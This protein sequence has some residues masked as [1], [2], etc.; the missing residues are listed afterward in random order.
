MTSN[1]GKGPAN[2]VPQSSRS[3]YSMRP[4]TRE[5]ITL[6]DPSEP[7]SSPEGRRQGDQSKSTSLESSPNHDADLAAEERKIEEIQE[8]IQRRKQALKEKVARSRTE[9]L[10]EAV[11]ARQDFERELEDLI[12]IQTEE[13]A[14]DP[15]PGLKRRRANTQGDRHTEPQLND[16]QRETPRE[17][18]DSIPSSRRRAPK[19]RDL[20]SYK[21]RNIQE[22]QSFI[23]S[24]EREFRRDGG[25]YI[26][27]DTD[28]IDH[29]VFAFDTE[30]ERRWTGY[31]E[32]TGIGNTTWEEFKTFL[33]DSIKDKEN[34]V[35][36]A[37]DSYERARQRPGQSIDSFIVYLDSLE[38]EL[39]ITDDAYRR[40][41]LYAK[42]SPSIKTEVTRRSDIPPDRKALISLAR[43]IETS[44][45]V[46]ANA[47][48]RSQKERRFDSDTSQRGGR[49]DSR[50]NSHTLSRRSESTIS[51]A[52]RTPIGGGSDT[53]P[54][55]GKCYRCNATGHLSRNCPN[56]E[57]YNCKEKGHISP[58]CTKP[59]RTGNGDARS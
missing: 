6:R 53:H 48:R 24:A 28:K 37:A 7:A 10:A 5:T 50:D 47:N 27:T 30:V 45:A 49:Q 59:K 26:Q 4:T 23:A 34:R 3:R 17:P 25:Y 52:N 15:E 29:C 21:G 40:R 2:D 20:P 33:L 42:L 32:E 36:D 1:K 41:T 58:N 57:C 18:S 55:G 43:R 16:D 22:A 51:D 54:T 8:E 39:G 38:R 44:E 19:L 31:E 46:I 56:V 14:G 9:E 13:E 12:R 11:R 35:F